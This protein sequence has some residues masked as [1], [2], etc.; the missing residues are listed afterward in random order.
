[1]G[2]GAVRDGF[3]TAKSSCDA[4]AVI[5]LRKTYFHF[6]DGGTAEPIAVTDAFWPDVMAG[7]IT[8]DGRLVTVSHQTADWP[9]WEMHPEGEELVVL[10]RG[11]IDLIVERGAQVLEAK[12]REPGQ[13]WLNLRGDWHRALVH[14][15][16]DLLFITHGA[17]T[18]HRP[19]RGRGFTGRS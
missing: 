14:E 3:A 6:R 5:D 19:V 10:I 11:S 16:S 17:G 2:R 15:P 7:K 4:R 13:A 9:H 8:L 18:Q 12:L 1:V